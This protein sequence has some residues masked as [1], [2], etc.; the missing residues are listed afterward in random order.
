[1]FKDSSRIFNCIF[2]SYFSTFDLTLRVHLVNLHS[3]LLIRF[4]VELCLQVPESESRLCSSKQWQETQQHESYTKRRHDDREQHQYNNQH[5]L[6]TGIQTLQIQRPK[7]PL[8]IR[9]PTTHFF[10]PRKPPHSQQQP[11]PHSQ[12]QPRRLRWR[13]AAPVGPE[14]EVPGLEN[15]DPGLG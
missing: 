7:S 3:I 13:R 10:K 11:R 2:S 5:S 9:R 6:F 4:F 1:M 12:P 14:K 8:P 15:R